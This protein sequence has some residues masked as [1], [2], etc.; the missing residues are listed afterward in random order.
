M[1]ANQGSRDVASTCP[2]LLYSSLLLLLITHVASNMAISNPATVAT[3]VH[4][5]T[6]HS[7]SP[8]HILQSSCPQQCNCLHSS[9]FHCT[10]RNFPGIEIPTNITQL[11]FFAV[12]ITVL[13]D[14]IFRN[15]TYLR[16]I[17]WQ[18]SS[19]MQIDQAIFFKLIRLETLDLSRNM[20]ETLHSETFHPL[21]EL[22]LLNLSQNKL[23]DLPENIFEGLDKLEELSL[24]HNEFDVIPFQVFAPLKFLQLLDLSYNTIFQIP[25]DSF[26][27]NKHLTS[28]FLQENNLE[29][30][31]SKSFSGLGNLKTLDLSNNILSNLPIN[32]FSELKNLQ[33]LNLG[34]NSIE[35]LFSNSF[36]GLNKLTCLNM[37]D[38]PLQNLPTKL[39]SSCSGLDTLIIANTQLKVLL[40]TDLNGLVNLKTLIINNNMYLREI[41]DYALVHCPKLQYI[42]FSGNSLST[43][44]QSLSNMINVQKINIGSNPWACD[45]RMVWFLQWSKNVSLVQNELQC[46]SPLYINARRSNMLLTLRGLNCKA[47]QLISTTPPLLYGLG[48]NALLHCSF[49]GSPHPSITWVTPTN[50]AFHWN[51][52]PTNIHQEFY[53]HPYAHYS[54]MTIIS[55]DDGARIRVLDNGTLYIR[56]IIRSD[57]GRYTCFATN[58]TANVT[59]YVMLN[60]DPITIYRIK[61]VSILVGAACAVGFLLATLLV[62][63]LRYL[64]H[65]FGWMSK[66]CCC[67]R[68]RVSPRAR[69][70]Y[71]M[72]DNI[73]QYKTQQ[74]ERLRENYTQQVHRI[75]DNCAQQVEWIQTSYQGQVKHLRDIRDYG[76]NHLTA[77]RDQYYDQVKKV[78]DYS[79]SQLNWV[80]E[81]YVFQ[82]NRIRKFSAHQVL[83]FRESYKYQQQ[84]LNKLL[85]NL[86]S[87]YLENCRSGSCGRTDSIV[88]DPADISN[89]DIYMKTKINHITNNPDDDTQSHMSLYYTPTELSESPHLSPGTFINELAARMDSSFD[90]RK[91]LE[92]EE[93]E[94]E[95]KEEKEI[96]E[97]QTSPYFLTAVSR[98]RFNRNSCKFTKHGY[99]VPCFENPC[100]VFKSAPKAN[101]T[102]TKESG[103]AEEVSILLP[104]VGFS[105]S[106]T[107][108][109]EL[110]SSQNESH[111]EVN[112]DGVVNKAQHETA[113]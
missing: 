110:S 60:V 56:N 88:F 108:L 97:Q 35:K 91:E 41:D 72:L 43:L 51:P 31:A 30:L 71:Q 103:S 113:L 12:N 25:D 21:S 83:R 87:L 3:V 79:T 65:R 105:S 74:L 19:I 9:A 95:E 8:S 100:E 57:C 84:T 13:H 1:R 50:L 77:L 62:N 112:I 38:N 68:D 89:M 54:N 98:Q 101:G 27:P 11:S 82:R 63:L 49:S 34:K 37:S 4:H 61:I 93:E 67:R 40:D 58:P 26:S 107:S 6:R 39:F 109:P 55:D 47:T 14:T 86:P 53:K 44:P 73:E 36:H 80:R 102:R 59:A 17:T 78:R 111:I 96:M 69:Q 24:S 46:G 106:S 42:D 18:N 10:S 81:N 23:H 90:E 22:K 15:A 85:E 66:C 32:L 45:C 20:L 52:N 5:R 2:T 48:S 76:T 33:Y 28:L 75:K 99:S 92:L 29:S 64:Y 94:E 104:V 16:N 70:I 7:G